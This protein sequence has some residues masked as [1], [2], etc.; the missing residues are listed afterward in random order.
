MTFLGVFPVTF[1][2]LKSDL[3]LGDQKVTWK[4]LVYM[5]MYELPFE[6]TPLPWVFFVFREKPA[7]FQLACSA[8]KC[9]S[10][11]RLKA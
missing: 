2:G 11:L 9:S 10:N 1:S 8:L 4:K 3:H 7:V 5:N 6:P